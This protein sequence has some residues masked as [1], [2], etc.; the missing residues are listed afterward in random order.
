M[1]RKGQ[2]GFTSFELVIIIGVVTILA[3]LMVPMAGNYLAKARLQ[4]AKADE[5]AIAE[6]IL[7]FNKDM[8]EWPIWASGT[9]MQPGDTVYAILY[10]ESGS[11][12]ADATDFD[13]STDSDT[14]DDQLVTD[15]PGYSA[16]TT[17]VRQ[18][19]GPYLEK[20]P[21]DPW[22]NKYYVNVKFLWTGYR[23]PG[24][25][26]AVFVISAGP[27]ELIETGFEQDLQTF[28]VSGDD[29]VHRIR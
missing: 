17:P 26:K 19:K 24:Q 18:M 10:S 22:G 14:L 29:I 7:E 16:Q 13:I 28:T 9:E 1:E 20:V 3:A 23:A 8:R 21:A 11:D 27:D 6:A 25:G 4:K 2:R 12:V 5:K 15:A